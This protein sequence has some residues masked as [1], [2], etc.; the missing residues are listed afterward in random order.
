MHHLKRAMSGVKKAKPS[1]GPFSQK[2]FGRADSGGNS[3][4]PLTNHS[5]VVIYL[6][7]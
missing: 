2:G 5:F 6:Q 1:K 3:K 7:G 4:K